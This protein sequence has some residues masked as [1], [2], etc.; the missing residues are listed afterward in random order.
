MFMS[1]KTLLGSAAV[2]A[3]TTVA[4]QSYSSYVATH[5]SFRTNMSGG[6]CSLKTWLH[7]ISPTGLGYTASH[8]AL[9]GANE[10]GIYTK[11]AAAA[12]FGAAIG[13][14]ESLSLGSH[15]HRSW[16]VGDKISRALTSK[17]IIIKASITG[18]GAAALAYINYDSD[19]H[20]E[21]DTNY[22]KVGEI[23]VVEEPITSL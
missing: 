6:L 16:D 10:P 3:A 7:E 2:L 22:V 5:G 21:L 19:G 15:A 4:E 9:K 20:P 23:I 17:E 11:T 13:C 1:L 18:L 14:L 12:I 8:I